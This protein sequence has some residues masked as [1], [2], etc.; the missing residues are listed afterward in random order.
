MMQSVPERSEGKTSHAK[1]LTMIGFKVN[2]SWHYLVLFSPIFIGATD[3][4]SFAFFLER[5]LTLYLTLALSFGVLVGVGRFFL[6]RN[7]TAPST[8]LL[9]AAGLLATVASVLSLATLS[10]DMP[11]RIASVVLLG[12]SEAFL[13][14]LWLHYYMEA[15]AGHL[16]RSFAVD[17]MAGGV[18]AFL[19][20]SFVPPLSYLVTLCMPAVAT[21]SLIA[22]WR[23]IEPVDAAAPAPV[24]KPPRKSILRHSLKTLLPTTVYAF[25]FGLLQGGFINSGIALLMAGNAVVLVG[26]VLAGIVIFFIPEAPETNADI[27]TIHRFSLLFFVLGIV[28]LSFLGGGVLLA[29]ETV[30]L[31]GF[32]LFDF[33]GL[34][35][36]VGLARRLKPGSLLLV[37]GGRVLVYVSL[38]VGLVVGRCVVTGFGVADPSLVLYSLCGAAITMLV[39]TVLTPFREQESFETQIA[40]MTSESAESGD[41]ATGGAAGSEAGAAAAPASGAHAPAA[42]KKAAVESASAQRDEPAPSKSALSSKPSGEPKR[43]DT[44]WRRTCR[45]IAE[46]YKLSPRETEIFFLIAKGR[47]AEYVQQKLVISMHTAKTHIANIYHKLGVHSSQEMLSLIE[48]FREEDIKSQKQD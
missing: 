44:P 26:I 30:I 20:C 27:D 2:L 19:T 43:A 42:S 33:G 4:P 34:I 48:T 45:G 29:S 15:A 10:A 7:K 13:M 22:N 31:A 5:Q 41:A 35:L 36:G 8:L 16:F 39:A 9:G 24:V 23:T 17:M 3:N 46:L 1:T 38:A 12:F 21:V 28:G 32:N 11:W 40:C 25:V 18:I 14:F 6:K 47:N 37:D